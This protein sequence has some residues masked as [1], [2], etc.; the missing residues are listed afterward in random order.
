MADISNIA[1]GNEMSGENKMELA[2]LNIFL[3]DVDRHS[4][5]I[6]KMSNFFDIYIKNTTLAI[7]KNSKAEVVVNIPS[8]MFGSL[9]E[10]VRTVSTLVNRG[11]TYILNFDNQN[12][13]V[14]Q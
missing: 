1:V 6:T 8:S 12:I 3:T 7:R 9:S 13:L 2:T 11:A 5:D 14:F 10:V 4:T